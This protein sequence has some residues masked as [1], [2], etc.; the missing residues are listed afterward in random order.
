MK[1]PKCPICGWQNSPC[2]ETSRM[3]GEIA[4]HISAKARNELW[5]REFN[6]HLETP[7]LDYF[8][9]QKA[10]IETTYKVHFDL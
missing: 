5:A 8:R 9:T 4:H 10:N 2:T 7:H 6:G 1:N 3:R